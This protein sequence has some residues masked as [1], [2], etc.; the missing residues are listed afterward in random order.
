MECSKEVLIRN[1]REYRDLLLNDPYRPQYHFAVPDDNGF[2][3][4]PN[5][6]F[7]ADGRYHLMYLY[8][9]TDKNAFHWGH[10]SSTDLIHWHHH[11]DALVSDRGDR[12][13]F[14]GGAFV[15][16]DGTAYLTFWKF[17]AVDKTEDNSGIAIAYSKPPYEKWERIKPI[18]VNSTSWGIVDL[19]INGE[20][21]HVS[22]ADPSNI[23]KQDNCY[24]MQAG[25]KLVLT[26]YG[27]A[28]SALPEY[29]GDYTDLFKSY[30]LKNWTFAHRFYENPHLDADF[31]DE[32]ED[33]MCPSFLPLSD[34]KSGGKL[35][36]KYLQLFIS[37]NKGGQYYIGTLK[38]EHFYPTQ[39]GRVTWNDNTYFAPEALI[40]DK[41]R[42]IAWFWMQDNPKN[43]FKRFGWSGVYGFPRVF[44][45]ENDILRMA[46]AEELDRLQYNEQ[47][48]FVGRI[49]SSVKLDVKN[50][51]SF[52]IKAKILPENAEKIGFSIRCSSDNSEHTDI[53]VDRK[54]GK[55]VFDATASGSDGRMIKEEAPFELADGETLFMDIFVDKSIVEVYVNERQA[56]CRRVYPTNPSDAV[57]VY[58]VSDGADFGTVEAF[59]MSPANPY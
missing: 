14:S 52:R 19:E 42:Q 51:E 29:Q 11:P 28:P 41:N 35:L 36:D 40:D 50:G 12:G 39:H 53:Y 4:D 56:I 7:F 5:G 43:D 37:H 22:C 21:K 48:L 23:W 34:K 26:A 58:A 46:P 54:S 10:I 17:A 25:N 33:D 9:N 55:L 27:D 45:L 24:Y 31:P 47:S 15:D 44:W 59:E 49:N 16:D 57:N 1:T 18:A 3:G 32:T 20:I 6:A 2:P 8:R 38:D 13:C 30:D